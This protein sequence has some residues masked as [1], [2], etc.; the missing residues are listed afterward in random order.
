[1]FQFHGET[2]TYLPEKK[3]DFDQELADLWSLGQAYS[4]GLFP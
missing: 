3:P 2:F 1:M 4:Y